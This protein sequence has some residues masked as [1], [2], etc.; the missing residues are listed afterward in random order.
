MEWLEKN[1]PWESKLTVLT[2]L[3]QDKVAAK[4]IESE[5][6]LWRNRLVSDYFGAKFLHKNILGKAYKL[7]RM[8]MESNAQK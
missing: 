4:R 5:F 8:N 2:F 1:F 3:K 6:E 7:N